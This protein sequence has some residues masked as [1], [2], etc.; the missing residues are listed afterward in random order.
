MELIM[1][2]FLCFVAAVVTG[3]SLSAF[4]ISIWLK[5]SNDSGNSIGK[6]EDYSRGIPVH[7]IESRDR[8]S[9]PR[10]ASLFGSGK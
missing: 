6:Y 9:P 3:F 2:I 10:S 5:K 4:I 8:V 7:V 1:F